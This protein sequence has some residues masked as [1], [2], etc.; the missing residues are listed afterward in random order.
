MLHWVSHPPDPLGPSQPQAADRQSCPRHGK[1][2]SDEVH[3]AEGS[4]EADQYVAVIKSA[5]K[6]GWWLFFLFCFFFF[7]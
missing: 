1:S 7:F 5:F 3:Q 4:W 2:I 6:G